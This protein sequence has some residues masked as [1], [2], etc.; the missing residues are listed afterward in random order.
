MPLFTYA[1][2]LA[3]AQAGPPSPCAILKEGKTSAAQSRHAS[4]E[5]SYKAGQIW[6]AF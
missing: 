2:F 1:C 6:P 5:K 4:V 3:R